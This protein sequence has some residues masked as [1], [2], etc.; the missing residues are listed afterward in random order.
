MTKDDLE[1]VWNEEVEA[2][3]R[4]LEKRREICHNDRC[5]N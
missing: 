2:Y 5:P 1:V 3:S 4:N